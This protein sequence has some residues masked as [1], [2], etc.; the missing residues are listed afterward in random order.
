MSHKNLPAVQNFS[1]GNAAVALPLLEDLKVL[2]EDN[3]VVRAT[4]V[5]DLG[6]GFVST[7]HVERI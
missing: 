7:S 5:E 4:L 2:D 3:E 1:Q 6:G